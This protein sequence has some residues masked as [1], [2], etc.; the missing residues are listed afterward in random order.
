MKVFLSLCKRAQFKFTTYQDCRWWFLTDAIDSDLIVQLIPWRRIIARLFQLFLQILDLT[1]NMSVE[2]KDENYS[3]RKRFYM[4]TR[5]SVNCKEE[6]Y[7]IQNWCS[8]EG[9]QWKMVFLKIFANFT[10]KHLRWS[11]FSIKLQT[12]SPET[13]LKR[14]TNTGVFLWNFS[15]HL[16]WRT[17]AKDCFYIV[18]SQFEF[19]KCFKLS[20]LLNWVRSFHSF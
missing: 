3:T 20:T 4:R 9:V 13:L 7:L 15:E 10:G 18:M 19:R 17:S 1:K 14:D 8:T 11:L 5:C 12:F 2:T 6:A 16:F